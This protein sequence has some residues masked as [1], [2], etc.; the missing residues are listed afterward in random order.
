MNAFTVK[1][2]IQA[3]WSGFKSRPWLFVQ[4]ILVLF[5]VNILV[6]LAQEFAENHSAEGI[7]GVVLA[8]V[9]AAAGVYVSFLLS[10]GQIA[11]FLSAH[12]DVKN[13]SLRALWHPQSFLR[14][15]G[16]TI[17][18]SL[19]VVLGFVAFIIPGIIL[20][21]ALSFVG[22]LVIE[23]NLSP[24][25]ALKES[26]RI[27]KGQRWKILLLGLACFA[28]NILGFL[29]LVVGIFVTAPVTYLAMTHAY[30][31]LST[32][33]GSLSPEEPKTEN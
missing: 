10:M 19:A 4:A 23:K 11:F 15:F 2:S 3:G 30:R 20:A 16:A 13:T 28:L 27:T 5:V 25:A 24:V 17:L 32:R 33:A 26:M 7:L 21:I 29:A 6:S 12:D 14:F 9:L 18:V 8:I 1:S 22:F 31:V